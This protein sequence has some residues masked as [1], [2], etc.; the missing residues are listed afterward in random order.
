MITTKEYIQLVN[1]LYRIIQK[2][3]R[4][5]DKML[6][7]SSEATQIEIKE[8]ELNYIIGLYVDLKREINN[9]LDRLTLA[10]QYALR[11]N[12]WEKITLY[13]IAEELNYSIRSVNRFKQSGLGKLEVKETD[14]LVK[15]LEL[16]GIERKQRG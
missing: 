6:R 16:C 5:L 12:F 11:N 8:R 13:Q 2:Q 14:T 9:Q 7:I 10:E 15:V 3:K 1:R 4:E